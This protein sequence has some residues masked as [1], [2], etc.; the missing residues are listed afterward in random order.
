ML[1]LGR[2]LVAQMFSPQR[3]REFDDR[4][5]FAQLPLLLVTPTVDFPSG[6]EAGDQTCRTTT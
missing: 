5:P 6:A 4:A 3:L 1:N 2:G